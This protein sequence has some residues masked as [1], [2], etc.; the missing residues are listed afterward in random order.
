MWDLSL[1]VNGLE[2]NQEEL[3]KSIKKVARKAQK[4][5]SGAVT[6][7]DKG[8]DTQ[9]QKEPQNGVKNGALTYNG[10][11]IGSVKDSNNN[12]DEVVNQP[13]S[14]KPKNYLDKPSKVD[15]TPL[16]KPLSYSFIVNIVPGVLQEE[17]KR[18]GK[19]A[20]EK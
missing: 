1:K 7:Q 8:F 18:I 11:P 16:E 17:I 19:K 5:I 15:Y 2:Q 14:E 3:N 12:N 4:S 6:E 9:S 20:K 10:Q 13:E